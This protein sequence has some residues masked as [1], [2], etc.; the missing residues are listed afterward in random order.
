MFVEFS[1]RWQQCDENDNDAN[2]WQGVQ[3]QHQRPGHWKEEIHLRNLV[4]IFEKKYSLDLP[5][6][7]GDPNTRPPN[8]ENIPNPDNLVSGN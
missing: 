1:A 7:V 3:N 2:Q 6:S 5:S 4:L 8:A